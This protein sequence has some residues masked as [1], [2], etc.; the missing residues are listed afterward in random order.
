MFQITFLLDWRS[1][2]KYPALVIFY[3]NACFMVSCIGWLVQFTPGSR[4]VIICRKDGTLRTREPRYISR[5]H[6]CIEY[7]LV[8]TLFRKIFI[9]I[10][11]YLQRR[12]SVLRHCLHPSVLFSDGSRG[13]VRHIDVRL[14]HELSSTW[15]DTRPDRQKECL[16]S[17]NRLVCTTRLDGC[18]YGIRPN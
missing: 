13:V 14:A 15:H 9:F 1:A 10:N 3:I 16:L 6:F 8:S 4:D 12:K 7:I 11:I 18:N 5:I 2:N 17:S